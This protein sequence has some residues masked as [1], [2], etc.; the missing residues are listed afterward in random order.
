MNYEKIYNQIIEKAKNRVLIG[1]KETHHII[2]RCMNGTDK[3]EN[4]GRVYAT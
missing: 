3:D 4:F 1:Y 2:P